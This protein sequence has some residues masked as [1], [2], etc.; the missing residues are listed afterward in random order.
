M[1]KSPLSKSML[2]SVGCKHSKEVKEVAKN[3]YDF[4][5][6]YIYFKAGKKDQKH[7]EVYFLL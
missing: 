5:F 1:E 2:C 7:S 4:K 6:T 3:F